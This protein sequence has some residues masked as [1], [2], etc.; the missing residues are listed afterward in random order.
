[1]KVDPEEMFGIADDLLKAQAVMINTQN[2]LI[3]RLM[4]RVSE[5]EALTHTNPTKPSEGLKG[6]TGEIK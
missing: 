1:M 5:L 2:E 4:N 6:L 3:K